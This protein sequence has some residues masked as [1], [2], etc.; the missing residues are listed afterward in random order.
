VLRQAFVHPDALC[1]LALL[2]ALGL[3]ALLAARRRRKA[4]AQ[5][6]DPFAVRALTAPPRWQ[7]LRSLCWTLGLTLLVVGVAGP[8]W[9]RDWNQPAAPGRDLVIVLDLSRSML[10][11][12]VLPSRQER[13]K[14]A[15]RDLS[16]AL[17]RRGG[18]RLALVAFAARPRLVCPLTHD[19]DHFREALAGLDAALPPPELRP[20]AESPSGTRIGAALELAAE[21]HDERF[22][23]FQDI[24]MISDGDDPARDEEW[25]AGAEAARRLG[26]P[27]HTVGVGN[28][29]ADSPIP[30]GPDQYLQHQRQPVRTRLHERP[31]RE[32]ARLTDGTYTPARTQ[33]LPLAELFRERLEVRAERDEAEDVL[34]AYRLRYAWFLGPAALLLATEMLLGRRRKT[35]PR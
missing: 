10:A 15:L 7:R 20:T 23:G 4:L 25:R 32:I 27:V 6:G 8:R 30:L 17:Q 29:D 2:P 11:E 18:H 28:P 26:I 35:T 24:L 33:V 9:G 13:A 1:L 5:L 21:A 34:P 3:V 19:L 31:L 16:F 22:R 12:D 14:Q